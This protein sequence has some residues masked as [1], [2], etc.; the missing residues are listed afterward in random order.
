MWFAPISPFEFQVLTFFALIF[1]PPA[2]LAG[3]VIGKRRVSLR[4]LFIATTVEAVALGLLV[5]MVR[6]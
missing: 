5:W 3:Y 4:F 6:G 2:F 1:V